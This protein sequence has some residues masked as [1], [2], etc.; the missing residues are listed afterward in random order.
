MGGGRY[1]DRGNALLMIS[2]ISTDLTAVHPTGLSHRWLIQNPGVQ[3]HL[4]C[5]LLIL[6]PNDQ[7]RRIDERQAY[8][9]TSRIVDVEDRVHLGALQVPVSQFRFVAIVET[10][11]DCGRDAFTTQ[12]NSDR[13]IS[14][15]SSSAFS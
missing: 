7:P 13:S 6:C 15:T 1:H 14:E 5:P 2:S 11:H 10:G 3:Q 9:H 4:A 8:V 12:G